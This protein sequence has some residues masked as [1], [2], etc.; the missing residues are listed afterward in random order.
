M[1]EVLHFGAPQFQVA[2]I[3]SMLIV[4]VVTMVETSADILA[5]GEII[6]T[7]VDSKR[8]GNGL[9]A[10]MISS[11]WRRCSARSRKVPLRRTSAWSP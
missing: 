1:P 2:A 4:I 3:L 11:A 5:V 8:L 10:D 6:G 9:R 7:P